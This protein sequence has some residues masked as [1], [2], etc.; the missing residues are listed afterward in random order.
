M[1]LFF[2]S[3]LHQHHLYDVESME[4]KMCK[5]NMAELF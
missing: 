5:K 4:Q 1:R 2:L 3:V